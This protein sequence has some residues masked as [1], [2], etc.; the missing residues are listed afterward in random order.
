MPFIKENLLEQQNHKVSLVSMV[1]IRLRLLNPA[2]QPRSGKTLKIHG[3]VTGIISFAI[4]S[5]NFCV[6]YFF[7]GFFDG[8]F[9]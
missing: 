9:L 8:N 1:S 2:P 5:E 6:V 7:K 3:R 4:T